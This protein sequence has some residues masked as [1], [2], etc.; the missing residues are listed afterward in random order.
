MV[1]RG[2]EVRE[3][4]Y[5][6]VTLERTV[7]FDPPYIVLSDR[8]EAPEQKRFGFA[9]HG[10]GQ[11]VVSVLDAED[12]GPLELPALP[13]DGSYGLFEGRTCV[14][15]VRQLFADW[16]V[17]TNLWLRLVAVSDGPLEATWGRTPGNPRREMRGTV[18]LRAPGDCRRF[19]AALEL[20][21]G[22]PTLAG[23]ETGDGEP[24]V[25][26]LFD[27]SERTYRLP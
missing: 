8:C 24:V 16:R 5:D 3:G 17:R 2:D 4:V 21:R 20:H 12:A 14:D 15:P 1:K 25:A 6:D 19:F 18:L 7:F 11:M 10:C 27:G 26:H 22:T 23:V 13:T 9:F